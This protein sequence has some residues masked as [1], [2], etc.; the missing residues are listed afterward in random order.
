MII[1]RLRDMCHG[2]VGSRFHRQFPEDFGC[3]SWFGSTEKL[4]QFVK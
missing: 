3:G 1:F 4:L 2:R